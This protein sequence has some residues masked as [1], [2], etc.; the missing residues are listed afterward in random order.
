MTQSVTLKF[1]QRFLAAR[2][3]DMDSL[4]ESQSGGGFAAIAEYTI[5]HGGTVYGVVLND[6]FEVVYERATRKDQLIKMKGSKYVQ[7][8]PNGIFQSVKA[9]LDN[10]KRVL[11]SGTACFVHG[12]L[13]FLSLLKVDTHNLITV[14]IVCHGTPSP[15]VFEDYKELYK[16]KHNA[17][18][19]TRFNFRDKRFGWQG[20]TVI[21]VDGVNYVNK[22]Y[23]SIFYSALAL[24]D[25]CYSCHYANLNRPGDITI[26]DCWGIERI[27]SA[28]DDDKGCSL[29]ILN[30]ARGFELWNSIKDKFD[31]VETQKE[32]IMQDNLRHPT[33][34]PTEVDEFW[35]DYD[36]FGCEYAFTR[37]CNYGAYGE[38]EVM[39]KK[40]YYRRIRGK[41]VEFCRNWF[42]Q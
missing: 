34:R 32:M 36:T 30:T 6:K 39:D 4:A 31:Y 23:S 13:M 7:S 38:Y 22:E 17:K 5:S 10:G 33:E 1:N 40:Q 20:P 12:L 15:K 25:C 42:E 9:D 14:D 27:N 26:G 3:K 28:F 37:Y 24:R 2:I 11:F 35:D 16:K 18:G 29:L 21:G 19:I 41:I 8:N